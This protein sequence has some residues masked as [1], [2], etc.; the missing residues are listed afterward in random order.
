M[1]L[2]HLSLLAISLAYSFSANAAPDAGEILRQQQDL[3]RLKNL[4]QAIPAPKKEEAT[5]KKN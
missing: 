1:K 2:K 5:R 4:P 3:D